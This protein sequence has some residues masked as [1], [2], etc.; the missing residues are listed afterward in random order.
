MIIKTNIFRVLTLASVSAL[1]IVTAIAC[2][3]EKDAAM[4]RG[5][6]NMTARYNGYF[7]A[8]E[9]INESLTGFRDKTKEDYTKI[10]PLEV[11]PDAEAATALNPEMDKAI[12][13]CSKV[14]YKHAMPDPNKVR[15]KDEE[16][17]AW[18]DDNWLVIGQSHFIKREYAQAIEKFKYVKK[19][20]VGEESIYAAKIWLAKTYIEQGEFSKAKIE[21]DKVTLDIKTAD[22]NKKSFKDYFSKKGKKKMSKYKR[23]KA[24]REKKKNKKL[25]PAKFSDK[26]KAEYEITFAN[27]Y[28]QQK[29]YKKAILHLEKAIKITKKRKIKARYMFILAQIYQETGDNSNAQYYYTKVAKSNAPYEMRFYAK[30]NKA[31]T[32]TTGREELRKELRKMLKD[33][34]NE[35]FKDQIYYVFAELDLKDGNVPSA[36]SNLTKSAFYS[37]NNDRQKGI[38]YLKLADIHFE[39]KDYIKAQKYY[40]SCVQVI[41]K[42]YENYESIQNKANGLADL[43]LN[44]EIVQR[45]DSLQKIAFMPEKERE[46]FLKATVKQIKKDEIRKKAEEEARL[47]A[48][49]KR[50]NAATANAGTGSKWYFYNQK[51]LSRGLNEYKATW[52]QR[53]DEDDWRRSNKESIANYEEEEID[54]TTQVEDKG[55]TVEDLKKNLP[56]TPE[57]VDSSN[58]MIITALYNLGIIYKEHLKEEQEAINYFSAVIDRQIEHEKVLPSAYQLYLLYKKKGDSKSNSFK[59]L[60]L[61]DYPNSDIARMLLDPDYIKKKEEKESKDLDD[62]GK[63]LKDYRYRRYVDVISACN[64]VITTNPQNKYINK[65]YLLKAYATSKSGIGGVPAVEKTLRAL[66]ALSPDS[67]EGKLAKQYLTKLGNGESIVSD[68]NSGGIIYTTDE[69]AVH[70]FILIFPNHK[71]DINPVKI[72]ISNFNSTYFKND[73][74]NLTNGIVGNNDQTVQVKSFANQNKAMTYYRAFGSDVSAPILGKASKEYQYFIITKSNFSVFYQNKD[75]EG[76]MKFFTEN[77]K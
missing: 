32:A 62:Y 11:Y 50:I 55:L 14:I 67:E 20:Y 75:I 58:N 41:P 33:A 49:Q 7:N 27:L 16:N 73:N 45:Q 72:N 74:L 57:A 24:R 54:D 6:H 40:D 42:S 46:K 18:I 5:F 22:A 65:Y 59:D 3:T 43:V 52:G 21:L 1:L 70:Y 60:I 36:K 29:D 76:Y 37:I 19:A 61:E 69:N 34:K 28:I 51:A 68:D 44:Y 39:E 48:K 15:D 26:L 66:Y 10:L 71:G 23:K 30:I 47:L 64:K 53:L 8:G 13:K 4:N 56:F 77:Y 38:S 2:S 25:E 35:E 17:C 9:I 31:L 12:E 63:T